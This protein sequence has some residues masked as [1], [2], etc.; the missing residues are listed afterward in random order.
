MLSQLMRDE[1]TG[2]PY[3]HSQ[4]RKFILEMDEKNLSRDF[5][6]ALAANAPRSDE[7]DLLKQ[8]TGK[9]EELGTPEQ[10]FLEIITIPRISTRLACWN[11]SLKS[12][13]LY[14]DIFD[15][16][17]LIHRTLQQLSPP[18]A[19]M[20]KD[21]PCNLIKSVLEVVLAFGNYLNGG[22]YRGGAYGFK[23]SALQK[24]TETKAT[25]SK[26]SLIHYIVQ[27]IEKNRSELRDWVT[28]LP[29][30]E[31]ASKVVITQVKSDIAEMSKYLSQVKAELNAPEDASNSNGAGGEEDRFK[32]KIGEF[33]ID[34]EMK[35]YEV[36]SR[37]EEMTKLFATLLRFYGEEELTLDEFIRIFAVF[38]SDYTNARADNA[39]DKVLSEKNSNRSDKQ[40]LLTNEMKA[41]QLQKKADA[42]EDATAKSK[43]SF[44]TGRA[45]ASGRHEPVNLQQQQQPPKKV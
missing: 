35:V 18:S 20:P 14:R 22:S 41:K 29:D 30:L 37:F 16:I 21:S 1:R 26:K 43:A 10:F 40:A 8:Y 24:L 6:Q 27:F 45:R 33:V 25:D 2:Q 19:A 13:P 32:K 36:R 31:G 3:T 11:V 34:F 23:L 42:A 4:V 5:L 12:W 44:M 7:I 28:A 38:A 15:R 39:K 9:K 17:D